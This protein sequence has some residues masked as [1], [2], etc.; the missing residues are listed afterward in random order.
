MKILYAVIDGKVS[1]GNNICATLLR[2]AVKAGHE[3]ELLTPSRGP[4]T[5]LLMREGIRINLVNLDRSFHIHKSLMLAYF[6]KIWRIDLVHTHT[7]LNAEILCRIACFL[8]GVPIICHQHDPTDVYNGHPI[9]AAYQRWLDR[10]TS[11]LATQF[12][13]V[14]RYRQQA[15]IQ[16]RRYQAQKVQLIYNG[17]DVNHF[18]SQNGREPVR[19]EWKLDLQQTAVGLIGR[20]EPSKGQETLIEAMPPVLKQ[21]PQTK[22]F[23]IGD[24]RLAGQPRFKK[25]RQ[26]IQDLNIG[27]NC[28]LLGFQQEISKLIQGL[29]IIVLPSWWEGHPLVLL[30]AMAARKPVVASRVGGTPEIIDND[31]TGLLIPPRDPKALAGAICRLIE[32][33][34][35]GERLA[36]RGYEK[37]KRQFDQRQM[38]DQV[39]DLYDQVF[40]NPKKEANYAAADFESN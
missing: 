33:P 20:L 11:N 16:K 39:L 22:F 25:Y 32:N 18:F 21:F 36:R 13:A 7:S 31:Q 35:F 40:F 24:D 19:R 15:M 9:I 2:S 1:G 10:T 34:E 37:V 5:D 4:L 23:I 30:E 29:D 26:M 8:A 6:L 28:F 27:Q 12:I 38:I 3:V 14:S 17:I